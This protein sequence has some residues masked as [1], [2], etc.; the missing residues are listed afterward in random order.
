MDIW[1]VS[2]NVFAFV[3]NTAVNMGM[4]ISFQDNVFISFG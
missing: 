1:A 2:L 4:Q 3:N